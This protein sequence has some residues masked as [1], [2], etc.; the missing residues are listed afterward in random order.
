MKVIITGVDSRKAFDVVNIIQRLYGYEC[1]L[2][3]GKDYKFQLP[4]IYGSSINRLR[5]TSYE[6]FEKD[7]TEL[8]EKYKDTDLVYL[9]VSENPTRFLYRY[10][11]SNECKNLLYL[12]PQEANFN[13]TSDKILF[14]EFCEKS[15]LPVPHSYIKKDI[16]T[17]LNNFIP[18][19]IKPRKGEGSVGIIHIND[20]SNVTLLNDI[21]FNDFVVQEKLDNSTNVEGAFFLCK[22]GDVVNYYTHQRLRTFPINGGVTVF[23]RSTQNES[24]V[25]I[26]RVLL[27]QLNWNGLAM[28]EFLYDKPTEQWKII[29]LNPRIWGSILLSAFNDTDLLKD[30]LNLCIGKDIEP[31]KKIKNVYIRW[32]YPFD[33]LNFLKR[34]ISFSDFINAKRN[35]TCYINFTYSSVFRSISYLLYFSFSISSFKRFKKKIS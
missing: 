23:S 19:I 30:Y 1:I 26:G 34:K 32:I 10:L 6:F 29:E 22:D 14:Q 2:C 16:P 35:E 13:L 31:P 3:A 9:P 21:N 8:V 33:F 27:K 11:Q 4:L 15:G 20:R 18:L 7:F 24:I 28:I 17:L 25:Q 12:L 5:N